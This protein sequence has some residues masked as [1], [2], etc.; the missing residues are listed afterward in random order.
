MVPAQRIYPGAVAAES[1]RGL[2]LSRDGDPELLLTPGLAE[3]RIAPAKQGAPLRAALAR[4]GVTAHRFTIDR[5]R[6]GTEYEL[7]L[8][9]V[10]RSAVAFRTLDPA[11]TSVEMVVASCYYGFHGRGA[12][13]SATLRGV[14]AKTAAFK[15][16]VGDNVYLDVHPWQ[17][18]GGF[19]DAIDEVVYV[20]LRYWLDDGGYADALADLPTFSTSDDHEF[21]NNYPSRQFWLSR[22]WCSYEDYRKASL[23]CLDLFQADN[24]PP[25]WPNERSY[26]F[27]AGP[28]S[29]FVADVR[30]DRKPADT[31]AHSMTDVTRANLSA[32]LR[33]LKRPG[34]LVLGQ[35]LVILAGGYTDYNLPYYAR[36]YTALWSD[37]AAAPFDVLIVSGDVHHSR[38]LALTLP[39]GRS[40]YEFVSSPVCH[41]P[42][43]FGQGRG[44]VSFPRR[45]E[46]GLAHVLDCPMAT[47][48]PNTIGKLSFT[49]SGETSVVVGGAFLDL[50]NG[51]PAPQVATSFGPPRSKQCI[52]PSLFTLCKRVS[53][54][55]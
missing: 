43:T 10:P 12:D 20:Y 16:L 41:I 11:A 36:E 27:E 40:A 4:Y 39:N 18:S 6:P 49:K 28:V 54:P 38:A 52:S 23:E 17:R 42:G 55:A 25:L 24:N 2:V 7:A 3:V 35:P 26:R 44:K 47:D 21:W 5:L 1:L 48:L 9:G 15:M 51:S 19:R 32:W 22:T 14:H 8:R 13:Y 53:N 33:G 50:G 34:V 31:G 30:S 46:A 29:V 37:I 45:C